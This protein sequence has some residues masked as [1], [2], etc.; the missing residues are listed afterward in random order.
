MG[1]VNFF[2]TILTVC[3][4]AACAP[5]Q[6]SIQTAIAQ[7]QAANPTSTFTPITPTET[8]TI[9]FTASP[10]SVASILEANGFI[11]HIELEGDCHCLVYKSAPST[12]GIVTIRILDTGEMIFLTPRSSF[13]I[14]IPIVSEVYGEDVASWV[15]KNKF[16]N[17]SSGR[18][19]CISGHEGGHYESICFAISGNPGI[20]EIKIWPC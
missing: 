3:L 1:K 8:P 12:S 17:S 10:T 11:E 16:P 9:L 7:T 19:G 15:A 6:A 14:I 13:D 18:Y 2:S 20:I 4:L 5:S